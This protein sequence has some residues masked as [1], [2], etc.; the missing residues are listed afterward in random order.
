MIPGAPAAYRAE[1]IT[2]RGCVTIEDLVILILQRGKARLARFALDLKGET[3]CPVD[4]PEF[5]AALRRW[6]PDLVTVVGD[7]GFAQELAAQVNPAGREEPVLLI[8]P[9]PQATAPGMTRVGVILPDH[10]D[11]HR[12]KQVMATLLQALSL[13]PVTRLA[14]A[15]ALEAHVEHRLRRREDFGF[16]YA[17]LDNFKGYNDKY[18]FAQGDLVIRALADLIIAQVRARGSPRDLPIHIGGDDFAVLTTPQQLDDIALAIC[19]AFDQQA[20]S[21]YSEEDRKA[22]G[23]LTTDRQNMPVTHPIMTV[24]IGGLATTVRPVRSYRELSDIATELK[25]AAKRLSASA[26]RSSYQPERRRATP[27]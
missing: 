8:V 2:S 16:L 15:W 23:I 27:G 5:L 22:G 7:P 19:A 18:G 6:R 25:N 3:D 24:S 13:N 14:G 26:R 21:F 4:P 17:D 10:F 1:P 12:P 20:P 11:A 9:M